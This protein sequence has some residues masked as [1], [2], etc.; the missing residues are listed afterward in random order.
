MARERR[1]NRPTAAPSEIASEKRISGK[2][3]TY[4]LLFL[5]ACSLLGMIL[6]R[7][8]HR[9]DNFAKCLSARHV[10][11]YGAYWCPHCADQKE[12]FGASFQYAPYIECGLPGNR[13]GEQQ[14]CKDAG[15]QHFPTWQF[16]PVGERVERVL[17][18]EDLSDR[19][20][21]PLP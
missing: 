5:A 15:I 16:P 7:Q 18:L 14:T 17:S 4:A 1:K 6:Y 2:K 21:C 8:R 12:K 9:Y 11:M 3:I 10:L 13:R 20:G 19:T